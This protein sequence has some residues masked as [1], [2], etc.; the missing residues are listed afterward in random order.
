MLARN[1]ALGPKYSKVRHRDLLGRAPVDRLADRPQRLREHFHRMVRRHVAGPEMHLGCTH[2][3]ARDKSVQYFGEEAALLGAEPA[4]DAEVDGDH[5]AAWHRR[6]GC[7]GACRRGRSR[8][9]WRAAG[10]RA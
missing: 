4:H 8:R 2:V 3:V 7:P 1:A 10:K 9:A 5:A 6:T